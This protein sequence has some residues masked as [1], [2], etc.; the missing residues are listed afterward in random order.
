MFFF[1]EDSITGYENDY[2][3][4]VTKDEYFE[5]WNYKKPYTID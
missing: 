2:R 4:I 5:S 1:G 3:D